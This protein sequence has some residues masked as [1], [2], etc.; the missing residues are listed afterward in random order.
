MN[1]LDRTA[2]PTLADG[3]ARRIVAKPDHPI[4]GELEIIKEVILGAFVA[5]GYRVLESGGE[6]AMGENGLRV[7]TLRY[8]LRDWRR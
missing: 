3:D 7:V 1:K 8:V 5:A 2:P 6:C 4:G